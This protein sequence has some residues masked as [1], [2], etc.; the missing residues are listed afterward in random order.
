MRNKKLLKEIQK[1]L[2]IETLALDLVGFEG[3]LCSD[4]QGLLRHLT[5]GSNFF[6]IKK[7]EDL[8]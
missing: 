4:T 8:F 6:I 7:G 2:S 1:C 3:A 5:Q